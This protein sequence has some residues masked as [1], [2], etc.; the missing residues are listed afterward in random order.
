MLTRRYLG[1]GLYIESSPQGR[2][3]LILTFDR[4]LEDGCDPIQ[5]C[6]YE[7]VWRELLDALREEAGS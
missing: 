4:S 5:V 3:E 2:R 7:D 1:N 6:L